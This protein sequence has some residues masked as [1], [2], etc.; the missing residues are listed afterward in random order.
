M[1]WKPPSK[2]R[3]L[4][5][6]VPWTGSQNPG[7]R[8]DHFR[9]DRQFADVSNLPPDPVI[10]SQSFARHVGFFLG[11][12][13]EAVPA[14]QHNTIRVPYSCARQTPL[15]CVI[16]YVHMVLTQ[17]LTQ[18]R[19]APRIKQPAPLW[20][21]GMLDGAR[22]QFLVRDLRPEANVPLHVKKL[23]YLVW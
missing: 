4:V 13:D 11:K 3:R 12:A 19:Y 10:I 1:T 23:V 18:H 16:N 17:T 8:A 15:W 21:L 20:V 5:E 9:R 2:M 14:D 7:K 6:V 22:V